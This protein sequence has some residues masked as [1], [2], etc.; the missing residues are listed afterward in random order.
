MNACFYC[1]GEATTQRATYLGVKPCCGR[2]L[3]AILRRE[4]TD[5]KRAIQARERHYDQHS[6]T[7]KPRR[8]RT[9]KPLP[10]QLELGFGDVPP[11]P[12][13]S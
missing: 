13:L 6:T 12:D 2:C 4:Q 1:G 5:E 3:S 10:G 8:K 11:L 9:R 7:K